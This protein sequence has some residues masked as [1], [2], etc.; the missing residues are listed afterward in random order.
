MELYLGG[1]LVVI[2]LFISLPLLSKPSVRNFLGPPM[3]RLGSWTLARLRPVGDPDQE[4]DDLSNAV[5]RQQLCAHVQRLQRILASDISMSAT[6]QIAN[7]IAYRQL[8]HELENAPDV[9]AAMPGHVTATRW[10][11]STLSPRT[12][13]S[14]RAPTVEI[15]DIGWRPHRGGRPHLAGPSVRVTT[16]RPERPRPRPAWQR[17]SRVPLG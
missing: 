16:L 17:R 12:V 6:R 7:R 11:P 13:P 3:I 5:R 8:L 1:W 10:N 9:C 4:A 15:G 14:E 2:G